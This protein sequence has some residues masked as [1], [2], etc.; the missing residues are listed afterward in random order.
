[1]LRFESHGKNHALCNHFTHKDI[2]YYQ[3]VQVHEFFNLKANK[4][5][6]QIPHDNL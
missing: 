1:M 6:C 4:S 2:K 5:S 3:N